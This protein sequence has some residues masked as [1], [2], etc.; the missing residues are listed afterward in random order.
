MELWELI[1][2][3]AGAFTIGGIFAWLLTRKEDKIE[4]TP[5]SRHIERHQL[6]Y[7]E[8]IAKLRPWYLIPVIL[9]LL[10]VA[11]QYSGSFS[12]LN[13]ILYLSLIATLTG[14]AIF[15]KKIIKT[16]VAVLETKKLY[17]DEIITLKNRIAIASPV[18]IIKSINELYFKLRVKCNSG[19]I[20]AQFFIVFFSPI[21]LRNIEFITKFL[22]RFREF[23]IGVLFLPVGNSLYENELN[24]ILLKKLVSHLITLGAV[25]IIEIERLIGNPMQ[26]QEWLKIHSQPL[27]LFMR[28]ILLNDE[29]IKNIIKGHFLHICYAC[30]EINPGNPNMPDAFE[31]AMNSPLAD[32]D[33]AS[34]KKVVYIPCA[35]SYELAE[36]ARH[37]AEM[38]LKKAKDLF[39]NAETFVLD[40]FVVEAKNPHIFAVIILAADKNPR[41]EEWFKSNR[42][43]KQ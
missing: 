33:A 28:S 9:F 25:L 43:D 23:T 42:G 19:I 2:L 22:H 40:Q 15:Y 31:K 29:N 39:K 38:H 1:A 12:Q 8:S 13:W 4:V 32:Y 3:L 5:G 7:E 11:Y 34:I 24:N 6:N 17:M 35:S 36:F 16:T 37:E 41:L 18:A 21:Y 26:V 27:A 14:F 10:Y 20:V 30:V